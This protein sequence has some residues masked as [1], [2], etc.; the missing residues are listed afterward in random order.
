MNNVD[1]YFLKSL[2]KNNITESFSGVPVS[3]LDLSSTTTFTLRS[4][5]QI[6]PK[7]SIE[8]YNLLP[9]VLLGMLPEDLVQLLVRT[10]YYYDVYKKNRYTEKYVKWSELEIIA[11]KEAR[12]KLF[13]FLHTEFK[14]LGM[15]SDK[16][17]E[18]LSGYF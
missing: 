3:F 8:I 9:E 17:K 4:E 14:K 11:A 15:T 18:R 2:M 7:K 10:I 5:L 6:T 13:V 1:F 16:V 12:E